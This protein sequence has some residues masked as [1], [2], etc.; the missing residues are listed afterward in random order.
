M[1][2]RRRAHGLVAPSPDSTHSNSD[3]IRQLRARLQ[4]TA[5]ARRVSTTPDGVGRPQRILRQFVIPPARL[6][7]RRKDASRT[8]RYTLFEPP[9]RRPYEAGLGRILP[10][11]WLRG[12][13]Y[14]QSLLA[15]W[16]RRAQRASG[17]PP[18]V[19]VSSRIDRASAHVAAYVKPTLR[20]ALYL[21][22]ITTP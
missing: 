9:L 19:G 12:R 5:V 6:S 16:R 22:A 21:S 7:P 10:R 20:K 13:L 18:E 8:G 2:L 14:G 17:L 1:E 11:P 4:K 3:R 15:A